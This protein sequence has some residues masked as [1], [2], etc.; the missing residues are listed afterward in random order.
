MEVNPLAQFKKLGPLGRKVV[1]FVLGCGC[2]LYL[3]LNVWS[4]VTKGELLP[5]KLWKFFG[6]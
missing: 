5:F 2:I 3:S 6:I 1:L 4:Y